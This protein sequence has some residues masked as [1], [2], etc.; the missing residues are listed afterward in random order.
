MRQTTVQTFATYFGSEITAMSN[1]VTTG[2]LNSGTITSGFGNIDTGSSTITTTGAVAT[3]ALT[4]TGAS[5]ITTADNLD[6]L[7]LISTDAD[8]NR[9]PN[10]RMYRNSGSPADGDLTAVVEFEG[11]N[12]NSQDVVYGQ[13]KINAADVSDGTEDANMLIGTMVDGTVRSRI[14]LDPT[15]TVF[16]EDTIDLDFRVESNGNANMLFV[17]GGNDRVGIGT[18][19]P[20]TNST[21]HIVSTASS[22]V[23]SI[24]NGVLIL[25]NN[26]GVGLG[27][28]SNNDR[29]QTIAFGDPEDNDI[30]KINYG[31]DTNAL[32]FFTNATQQ[33]EIAST[34]RAT[35]A[36]SVI[37]GTDTDTSNTGNVALDFAANQ[38]F[39]LT[40]TGNTTLTNPSTESVGQ[41]G[42]IAFIQDG[43]G[44]RTITLGTDYETAGGVGI[45]LTTAASATD[46]VPYVV[47]ASGRILLGQPQKAFS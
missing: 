4:T 10:L 13:I 39:V 37:G 3:G 45:T 32:T 46:L 38:N 21:L 31:H 12:D 16:N 17:D 2:A 5:S 25:E 15:E 26:T 44:S 7:S 22:G 40:L 19:S 14:G 35:F 11:R 24:S 33:L 9:G 23:S 36:A 18:A 6:T 47:V 43:T 28:L 42:F 34:G 20:L 30:G 1:L 29:Q 27:L 41:S 8:A